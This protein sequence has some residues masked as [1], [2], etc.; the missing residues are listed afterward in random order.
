MAKLRTLRR[1]ATKTIK[2]IDKIHTDSHL[3]QTVLGF[4]LSIS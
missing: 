1:D 4:F 2:Q 3:I